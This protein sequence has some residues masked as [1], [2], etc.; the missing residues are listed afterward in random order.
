MSVARGVA[1]LVGALAV[2]AAG[3]GTA[4]SAADSGGCRVYPPALPADD[5]V[6]VCGLV[7]ALYEANGGPGGDLGAPV[8]SEDEAHGYDTQFGD[9]VTSFTRGGIYRDSAT[10][11][12][13]IGPG[14]WFAYT[15]SG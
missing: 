5:D 8:F 1:V 11:A 2:A 3:V 7:L 10:G 6:A 4:G 9:R 14:R 15:G 13:M 12:A